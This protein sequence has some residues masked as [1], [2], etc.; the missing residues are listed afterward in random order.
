V[1]EDGFTFGRACLGEG[2]RSRTGIHADTDGS[3]I[4]SRSTSA[5]V[6]ADG[7]GSCFVM[8]VV[9]DRANGYAPAAAC[10]LT[11]AFPIFARAALMRSA[12][13]S[14]IKM[15]VGL[16]ATDGQS[17]MIEASPT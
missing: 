14:A 11:L 15:T 4:R 12:T 13:I 9:S 7:P 1:S 8:G 5:T 2:N 6:S 3:Q 16:V 17:G 10:D